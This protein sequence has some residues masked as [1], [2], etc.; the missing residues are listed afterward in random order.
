MRF[1]LMAEMG[2]PNPFAT[3]RIRVKRTRQALLRMGI[4]SGEWTWTLE[5]NP[6]RTGYHAHLLQHGPSIPQAALQEA[7]I[8][9]GGG[10]PWIE[11]IKRKPGR[12]AQYGL[13]GYG[14]DGYGLKKF[15]AEGDA[16]F[17]LYINGG[18]IEH[19]TPGFFRTRGVAMSVRAVESAALSALYPPAGGNHIVCSGKQV[20]FYTSRAGR[21][22]LA[23]IATLYGAALPISDLSMADSD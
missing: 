8:R 16:E 9:A 1:S 4:Q 17:A 2:D 11:T 22:P 20:A 3:A 15:R 14:A 13:T 21:V 10:I 18:R 12:L 7:C 5:Q 6:E 23:R 19:H